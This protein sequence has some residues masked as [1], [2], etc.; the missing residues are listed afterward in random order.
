ML[1]EAVKERIENK[2]LILNGRVMLKN[3][4]MYVGIEEKGACVCERE[5]NSDHR[6]F[7]DLTVSEEKQEDPIFSQ[8]AALLFLPGVETQPPVSHTFLRPNKSRWVY[9]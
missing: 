3:P 8:T 7:Y 5:K 1:R 2:G 9:R 6:G 4:K